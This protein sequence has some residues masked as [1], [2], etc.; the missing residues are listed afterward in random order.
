MHR[1]LRS[2]SITKTRKDHGRSDPGQ[3]LDN[4]MVSTERDVLKCEVF[5]RMVSEPVWLVLRQ[6]LSSCGHKT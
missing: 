1:S 6:E 3:G 4:G 5:H 2:H